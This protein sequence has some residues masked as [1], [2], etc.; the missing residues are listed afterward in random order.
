[1]VFLLA[2]YILSIPDLGTEDIGKALEWIFLIL[3]PNFNVGSALMDMFTNAGYKE[4][5]DK[6]SF[7][8]P[9][10]PPNMTF[11]CCPGMHQTHNANKS[12][13]FTYLFTS[14]S[15]KK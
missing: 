15:N 14:I 1:M 9:V 12:C 6:I 7:L 3:M 5:C 11:G 8:C 10:M 2:V 13:Q 4:A